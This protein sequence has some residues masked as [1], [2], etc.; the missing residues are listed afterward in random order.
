MRP[1]SP[2]RAARQRGSELLEGTF[3]LIPMI[4]YIFLMLDLTLMVWVKGTLQFAVE[5]GLRHGVASR[6]WPGV[7]DP[8]EA[9]K[10]SVKWYSMGLLNGKN[11]DPPD[12][13]GKPYIEKVQIDYWKRDSSGVFVRVDR[14][15]DS[16]IP[17]T[18]LEVSVQDLEWGMIA[19]FMRPKGSV[20]FDAHSLGRME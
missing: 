20:R 18:I 1:V 5:A 11:P 16:D 7:S 8:E 9:I 13:D 10:Q 4:A 12:G 2:R 15:P 19:P 17:G 3:I 6:L 14:P